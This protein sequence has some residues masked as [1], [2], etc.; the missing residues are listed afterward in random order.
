MKKSTASIDLGQLQADLVAATQEVHTAS[1][2][3]ARAD[4]AY[5]A[6][7][8]AHERARVSLNGAVATLKSQTSVANPYAA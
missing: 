8:E 3:K 4:Q 7:V 1:K 5:E 6:A 2:A